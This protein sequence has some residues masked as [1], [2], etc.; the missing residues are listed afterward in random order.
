VPISGAAG[1]IDPDGFTAAIERCLKDP[2]HFPKPGCLSVTQVTEAGT[3]YTLDELAVLT[4]IAKARGLR[5]HMDGARFANAAAAMGCAPA[6]LTWRLGVDALSFGATKNG[7]MAAEVVILFDQDLAREFTFRQKR[8]GH[9]L[10]KQRFVAAQIEAF[11]NNGRWLELAAHANGMAQQL[12]ERL[13]E[14]D[15]VVLLYPV[16]GNQIFLR[17]P[18]RQIEAL[19]AA[20][21]GFSQWADDRGAAVRLVTA[22]DTSQAHVDTV[23][24]ILN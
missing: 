22:F 20:N 21:I 15:G 14:A 18:E 24:D 3:N 8:G 10:S 6:E 2:L 7:A 4:G 23:V 5:V 1:K 16:D 9:V 13:S 17:L 12:A 11:V 19:K